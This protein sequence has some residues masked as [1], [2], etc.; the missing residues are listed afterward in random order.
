MS[1]EMGSLHPIQSPK[2]STAPGTY[3]GSKTMLS[4]CRRDDGSKGQV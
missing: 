2:P 4:E 3:L 1:A